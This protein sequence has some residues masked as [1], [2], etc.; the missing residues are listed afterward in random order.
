MDKTGL[1]HIYTG[2]GKGKTT[3]AIGLGIRACGNNM[4]VLMVQFLK[5]SNTSELCSLKRLEPDFTVK[6]GFCC[7]KFVWNMTEQELE[8]ARKEAGEIFLDVKNLI[9]QDRYDLVILDE[10][11]G[12]IS[13]GF[14]GEND[15]IGMIKS[16]PERT[17]LV[18]TGRNAGERLIEAADYVSEIKPVK[19]PYEKGISARKGIE[20]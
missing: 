15:V 7:R 18:L 10:L 11:L 8:E 19:H 6:R 16:K 20:F 14:I 5:S 4:K 13:L 9:Q 1:V 2:D 17:E 3:A 12:V